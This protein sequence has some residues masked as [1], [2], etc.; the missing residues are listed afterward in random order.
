[1]TSHRS[2]ARRLMYARHAAGDYSGTTKRDRV[3]AFIVRLPVGTVFLAREVNAALPR[4][5]RDRLNMI[6][7][8]VFEAP[9]V[10][11]I[12]EGRFERIAG[13]NAALKDPGAPPGPPQ[14]PRLD[15][16]LKPTDKILA[17]EWMEEMELQDP[18]GLLELWTR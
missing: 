13:S 2:S 15:Q 5:H 17:K 8:L 1:M 4:T 7:H 10:R 9:F 6:A 18:D 14:L 11:R 16:P 12:G 3:Y